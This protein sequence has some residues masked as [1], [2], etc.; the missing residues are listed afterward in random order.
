VSEPLLIVLYG[1]IAAL[2]PAVLLATFAVLG[3][4]RGR[5]NGLVFL[6]AFVVG[7]TLAYVV[8][9]L[10]GS[11]LT[12][13]ASSSDRVTNMLEIAG[14][15]AIVVIANNRRDLLPESAEEAA[16]G[17]PRSEALFARLSHVRPA[18][19][20]GV[21]MPLGIGVKR[22]VIAFLAA[23]SAANAGLAQAES[24]ALGALYIAVASTVV[25]IP[26]VVYLVLGDRAET[27]MAAAKSWISSHERQVLAYS[28]IA[29]GFFLVVDG[30]FQL[31]V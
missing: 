26:V 24:V 13:G 16:T 8:A 29:F 18:V 14:G 12:T 11:A 4:G 15:L 9:S 19:S 1:I 7:Q 31:L 23:T 30:V 25:W 27:I 17:T 3:S 28:A 22:L 21:G 2:S 6:V 10:I 20:F 5:L